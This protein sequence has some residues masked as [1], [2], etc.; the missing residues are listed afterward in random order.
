MILLCASP[1]QIIWFIVLMFGILP[2]GTVAIVLFLIVQFIKLWRG[3]NSP[4]TKPLTT[5]Q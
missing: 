1:A 5:E 3:D 4:G 2:F